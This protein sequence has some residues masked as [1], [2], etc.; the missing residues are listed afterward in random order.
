MAWRCGWPC[1]QLGGLDGYGGDRGAAYLIYGPVVGV[2]DLSLAGAVITGDVAG[3]G[4]QPLAVALADLS[5]DGWVD[6]VLG[7]PEDDT[8]GVDAGAV[9][10][11]FSVP[12]P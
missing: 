12:V 3:G 5:G 8:G 7:R 9:G 11:F 1:L 6:G 4:T 10:V 2:V